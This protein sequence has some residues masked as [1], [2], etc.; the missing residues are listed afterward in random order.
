[1]APNPRLWIDDHLEQVLST[2]LRTGV[3]V[4]GAVVLVGGLLYLT[5]F[6][7]TTPDFRIFREEPASL[8][9]VSDIVTGALSLSS[10][11]LIQ[12]GVLFLIAT[13]LLRVVFS[14]VVF[15]LQRDLIYVVVTSIVLVVLIY[16]LAGEGW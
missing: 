13:P 3:V 9:H 1:M 8:R 12:L 15:A 4:A 7:S 10:R 6:G 14:V 11:S 5:R 16:S 2:I